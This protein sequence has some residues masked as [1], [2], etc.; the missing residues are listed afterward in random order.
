MFIPTYTTG[1]ERI[2]DVGKL[3]AVNINRPSDHDT[4][5]KPDSQVRVV[6]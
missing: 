2:Q 6:G 3:G 1:T 5:K 4:L